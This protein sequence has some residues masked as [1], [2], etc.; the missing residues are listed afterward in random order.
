MVCGAMR[1]ITCVTEDVE[2]ILETTVTAC[3]YVTKHKKV[4]VTLSA[5]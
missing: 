4:A 1:R 2:V 3:S 5:C